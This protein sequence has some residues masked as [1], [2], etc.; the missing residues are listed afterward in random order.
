MKKIAISAILD[1]VPS[2]YA[3][4]KMPLITKLEALLY[5]IVLIFS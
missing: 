3:I 4:N 5:I 2:Y 1:G